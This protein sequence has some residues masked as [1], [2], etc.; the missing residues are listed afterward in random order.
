LVSRLQCEQLEDRT[1]PANLHLTSIRY[2]D[3]HLNP[4]ARPLPGDQIRVLADWTG[5]DMTPGI[6]YV[7]RFTV[8]GV[9]LDSA[10]IVTG[11]G[12]TSNSWYHDGWTATPGVHTV[13][14]TID[15]SNSVPE[16]DKSDNTS[17]QTL[18]E[19]TDGADNSL[20]NLH[21]DSVQLL[22]DQQNPVTNPL[23]D[24]PVIIRANWTGTQLTAWQSYVVRITVDGVTHDSPAFTNQSL[25]AT[26][27]WSV[28]WS[29]TEGQHTVVATIDPANTVP[30]TDE[31]DNT[32]TVPFTARV[33]LI[34][35]PQ[36]TIPPGTPP[37]QP[38]PVPTAAPPLRLTAVGTDAGVPA[39]V[40]VYNPD[41]T[42]RFTL[43]PYESSFTGGV[44]VAVEDVTG[45]GVPD[46]VTGPGPGR[47]ALIKVFDGVTGTE[48]RSFLAFEE[49]F[50]G[51]VYVDVADVNR[52]GYADIAISPDLG[53]GPRVEIFSGRDGSVLVNFF[54]IDDPNFRGGARI[55]LGDV[56]GDG[57][58]DLVVS[59]GFSGGPRISGYDGA[60]LAGGDPQHLFND[61]FAFEETLRNGAYVALGDLN[62]DGHDD[63]IFGAGPGG[64]PRVLAL[65]GQA[66]I[67]GSEVP[68]ANFFAGDTSS[69]NGVRVASEDYDGDG[70][71]DI[72]AGSSPGPVGTVSVYSGRTDDLLDTVTPFDS[73]FTGGVYVGDSTDEP[74][75]EG[76]VFPAQPLGTTTI[77]GRFVPGEETSVTFRDGQG[78]EATLVADA[79][80]NDTVEVVTPPYSN[81][82]ADTFTQSGN[83]VNVI[84]N[85]FPP[86]GGSPVS[87]EEGNETLPALPTV[88]TTPGVLTESTLQ[89]EQQELAAGL[90]SYRQL[91]AA[92]GAPI[93]DDFTQSV[94]GLEENLTDVRRDIDQV[95]T[96]GQ[97][98]DIGDGEELPADAPM[99]LDQLTASGYAEAG[100]PL[101]ASDADAGSSAGD[102]VNR[103][104]EFVEQLGASVH[105]TTTL[106]GAAGLGKQL[107]K[108]VLDAIA[109][110]GLATEAIGVNMQMIG[111]IM[112]DKPI[113]PELEQKGP[114]LLGK[115]TNDF[116]Q[117]LALD[118]VAK[119]FGSDSKE[120]A[121]WLFDVG[122]TANLLR[123]K[124]GTLTGWAHNFH[125]N[126]SPSPGSEIIG[127]F[128]GSVT[129]NKTSPG[130][131]TSP[132]FSTVL[133]GTVTIV[134]SSVQPTATAG[135][136]NAFGSATLSVDGQQ[137][138]TAFAP[139]GYVEY[140]G[141]AHALEIGNPQ[142]PPGPNDPGLF[143]TVD[144]SGD[145]LRCTSGGWG[146][147]TGQTFYWFSS[148]NSPF[149]LTR[150]P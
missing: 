130:N 67:A 116:A 10:T 114:E 5:T 140:D 32:L 115:L 88:P 79:V 48:V 50:T 55:S 110:G 66:A 135:V 56:T 64:S 94:E 107:G 42:L 117:M 65:D 125:A 13:T 27:S 149:T 146:I 46:I 95:R 3:A 129:V 144:P 143:L 36:L 71:G 54:A 87:I 16:T 14:V 28:T 98:V 121:Q 69:R 77:H 119:Y 78:Y 35:A 142:N 39:V 11:A 73:G 74:R 103:V 33:P 70:F 34:P 92:N 127:T 17:T 97:P 137:F 24:H 19:G 113:P 85:Q 86:A 122:G 111:D 31:T 9:S 89:A 120:I 21:I 49:S 59:A 128:T 96:T 124:I 132:G 136:L 40:K 133:P 75:I 57:V 84:V 22:D 100:E 83:N 47:P 108:E 15:P 1:T 63:M 60:S 101:P 18:L 8:D 43:T 147:M 45:D 62:G 93:N 138:T 118:Q 112:A 91:A 30:E 68:L 141:L 99:L 25:T 126:P 2:L 44:R 82:G 52:D 41:H 58:P 23:P 4:I 6:G 53:G 102:L 123:E 106:T 76:V 20:T 26:N 29:G 109:W 61:F 150:T 38:R 51:G 80:S 90:D 104:G 139:P 145:T 105:D 72:L 7:V 37:I 134:V 12:A 148:L 81:A 131:A